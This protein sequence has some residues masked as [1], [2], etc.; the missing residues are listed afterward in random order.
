M[1]HSDRHAGGFVLI[2]HDVEDY[3]KWKAIFD[4]AATIRAE[5]GELDFRL[6]RAA[7]NERRIV[8]FSRWSSLAAAKAF[9]ESDALVAI[10]KRAG[11]HAPSF[12]Y[13]DQIECGELALARRERVTGE[14][15]LDPD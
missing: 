14:K 10:R 11:V 2:T 9:F 8:H 5:A 7:E 13:L 4:D 12:H 1:S 3:R 6:L 15:E